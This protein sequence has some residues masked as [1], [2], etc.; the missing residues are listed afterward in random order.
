MNGNLSS[1]QSV[2]LIS[3]LAPVDHFKIFLPTIGSVNPSGNRKKLNL[4]AW[5]F[6]I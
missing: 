5:S 6:R 1:L 4:L 3:D 2:S